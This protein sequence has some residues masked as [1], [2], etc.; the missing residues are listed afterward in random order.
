MTMAEI[1]KRSAA[2]RVF[3][4]I[5]ENLRAIRTKDKELIEQLSEINE[6][7]CEMTMSLIR[8]LEECGKK[9]REFPG[10]TSS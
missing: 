2:S 1:T 4:H 5:E 9:Q 7:L 6:E 3:R 8:K 10:S